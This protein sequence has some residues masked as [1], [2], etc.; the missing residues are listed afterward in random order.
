[1]YMEFHQQLSDE[2]A[3]AYTDMIDLKWAINELR[4]EGKEKLAAWEKI[5]QL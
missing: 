1:M 3:R 2:I 4:S 5:N